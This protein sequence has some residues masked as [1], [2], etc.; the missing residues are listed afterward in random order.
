MG[1]MTL[2]PSTWGNV[3]RLVFAVLLLLLLARPAPAAAQPKLTVV[4]TTSQIQDFVRNVGGDRVNVLG[5][6]PPATDAHDYE[7]TAEEARKFGRADIVFANGLGLEPW[8]EEMATNVRPGVP[9]IVLAEA[10]GVAVRTSDGYHGEGHEGEGHEG[11]EAGES[12]PHIWY[13]PTNVQ[14]MVG[15]IRDTLSELDPAGAAAYAAA[16]SSYNDQLTQLDKDIASQ[17]AQIP[18]EQRKLVTNHDAFGYYIDRYNF[19]FIGSVIPSLSTEA[20]PSA[21]EVRELIEKIKAEHVKAI[22]T[23]EAFNPRLERQIAQEAGVK[24]VSGLYGDSLGPADSEGDTYIK[25]MRHNT[26]LIVDALR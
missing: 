5:I 20:E 1:I 16:A 2:N 15:A 9:V 25:A 14:A 17:V 18:V 12:D 24:V 23:E 26:Q 7:P 21:S 4:A 11:E 13:D 22:F 19:T 3:S 8:L 10:P 6:L